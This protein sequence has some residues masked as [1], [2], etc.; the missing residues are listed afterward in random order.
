MPYISYE[1]LDRQKTIASLIER[2]STES[3]IQEIQVKDTITTAFDELL[4][5]MEE[6][7]E[8]GRRLENLLSEMLEQQRKVE[9]KE[10]E[11]E[12]EEREGEGKEGKHENEKE[13][14]AEGASGEE[15]NEEW[16]EN[17]THDYEMGTHGRDDTYQYDTYL[18]QPGGGGPDGNL[19]DGDGAGEENSEEEESD[20]NSAEA[21]TIKGYLN[22]R[23][24]DDVEHLAFHIRR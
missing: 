23:N 5:M 18:K 9:N 7:R 2:T 8:I 16:R 24:G 3:A 12:E 11:K 13:G 17:V 22:G 10:K 21:L 20:E 4:G 14:E 15:R 19:T 1:G 6:Q